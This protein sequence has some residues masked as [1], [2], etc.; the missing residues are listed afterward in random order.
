MVVFALRNAY[1]PVM[2]IYPFRVALLYFTIG[3]A[4]ILV[5]DWLI[6]E[7]NREAHFSYL[8]LFK[9]LFFV[10]CTSILLYF[11][12][13][14]NY[15]YIK[16]TELKYR[17]MF[18]E[19]PYPML[20]YDVDSLQ[21]LTVNN[22]F[23]EKYGYR[24]S[25]ISE[26]KLTAMVP[27]EDALTIIDFVKRVSE[28]N[29]SDSGIWRL[30]NKSGE[31]FFAKISSHSSTFGGHRARIMVIMDVD[32]EMRAKKGLEVSE[33]KLQNLIDNTDDL[34]Y[35]IDDR[36]CIVNANAAFREKFKQIVGLNEF[37]LPLDITPLADS[38]GW[39]DYYKR[40][41]AGES[42]R[43]EKPYVDNNTGK[44]EWYEIVMHPMHDEK[45][46]IT[47]VGCF[48]RDITLERQR[49]EQ[50][51]LQ[52]E[53]LKDIAWMESHELRKSLTN[54]MMLASLIQEEPDKH[55]AI[56]ELLPL[57]QQSCNELDQVVKNIVTKASTVEREI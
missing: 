9:G 11:I 16:R 28:K 50:I 20:V 47:A 49:E 14:G 56:K 36:F 52:L 15:R 53:K 57:L 31:Q 38:A 2:K 22:A 25:D 45:G 21:V 40:A 55:T 30:V 24:K 18:K 51:R 33:K 12:I 17:Y 6:T 42:L 1:L 27:P 41:I 44:E 8:Q 34:I 3:A 35:M 5:S 13:L 54:V 46:N 48:S 32:E 19:N 10:L 39:I 43:L 29:Y 37:V 7:S 4:W 26:L 23:L